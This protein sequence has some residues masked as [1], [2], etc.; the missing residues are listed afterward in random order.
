MTKQLKF[1]SMIAAGLVL[2]TA[3]EKNNLDD[4]EVAKDVNLETNTM[5]RFIHAFSSNTINTATPVSITTAPPP[6]NLFV[7]GTRLNGVTTASSSPSNLTFY[8]GAFPGV[9][10]TAPTTNGSNGSLNSGGVAASTILP[11]YAAFPGG[12]TRVAAVLNRL[13][14]ASPADTVITGTFNLQNGKRYSLIAGDTI[15]NQRFYLFEDNYTV[16]DRNNYQIRIINLAPNVTLSS[17]D[18][19]SRRRGSYLITGLPYRANTPYFQVPIGGTFGITNDTLEVRSGGLPT[20]L[21]QFNGFF[22]V[23]QRAYTFVVRGMSNL[24]SSNVRS[25]GIAGYLNR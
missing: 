23:S 24:P 22:P 18:I 16:P 14:G 10:T 6:F 15:P 12:V 9:N 3:C 25:L 19:Y 1:I 7:N 17:I 11:D 4:Y 20:I 5:V 2:I 13:T 8:F 21:A